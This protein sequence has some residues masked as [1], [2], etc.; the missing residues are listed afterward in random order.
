MNQDEIKAVQGITRENEDLDSITL[1]SP[2]KRQVKIYFNS[3]TDSLDEVR[4]RFQLA[5]D[6]ALYAEAINT[7]EVKG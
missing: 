6:A 2:S 7:Q 1:G 3:K 4:R 5:M